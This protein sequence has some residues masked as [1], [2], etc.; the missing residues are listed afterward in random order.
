MNTLFSKESGNLNEGLYIGG[1]EKKTVYDAEHTQKTE[2]SRA[3][4]NNANKDGKNSKSIMTYSKEDVHV[5]PGVKTAVMT[6]QSIDATVM[7]LLLDKVEAFNVFDAIIIDSDS[8]IE[9]AEAINAAFEK[10]M[11]DFSIAEEI[12][13]T[14]DRAYSE[15]NKFIADPKNKAQHLNEAFVNFTVGR[16][17][18]EGRIDI[19]FGNKFSHIDNNKKAVVGAITSYDQYH[20]N[21]GE[22]LVT[23]TKRMTQK[24]ANDNFLN[25]IED[26]REIPNLKETK[27]EVTRLNQLREAYTGL[28]E[29]PSTTLVDYVVGRM[30]EGVGVFEA[31]EEVKNDFSKEEINDLIDIFTDE[32][33]FGS[34]ADR[35]DPTSFSEAAVEINQGNLVDTFDAME[36]MNYTQESKSHQNHLRNVMANIVG[37]VMDTDSFKLHQ[38]KVV[39]EETIGMT[40]QT[41]VYI[42]HE[43]QGN[44]LPQSG[45]L[46]EGIKMSSQEVFAHET[47]HNITAQALTM[48][49]GTVR[50]ITK[51]WRLAKQKVTVEDFM[52]DPGLSKADPTYQAKRASAKARY[53]HIFT[54]RTDNSLSQSVREESLGVDY[55]RN[56]SKHL[57]E[58]VAFGLTNERF[59]QILASDKVNENPIRK[60]WLGEGNI[61]DKLAS[62]FSALLDYLNMRF[63]NIGNTRADVHLQNLVKELVG[64]NQMQKSGL[65]VQVSK[66]LNT[67]QRAIQELV[68]LSG[69]ALTDLAKKP[70]V[71]NSK[72]RVVKIAGRGTRIISINA[73]SAL[74]DA[75]QKVTD[76]VNGGTYGFA[77]QV[78]TEMTRNASSLGVLDMLGRKSNHLVDQQRKHVKTT[79]GNYVKNAFKEPLNEKENTAVTKA[80]LKTDLSVL[81]DSY[82]VQEISEILDTNS[83][84]LASE[85]RVLN[86]QLKAFP[87]LEHFYR[88]SARNLGHFMAKGTAIEEHTLLNAHNI[89]LLAG[90]GFESQISANLNP[91]EEQQR[92]DLIDKLATLY[93]IRETAT[94]HRNTLKSVIDREM[95]LNSSENGFMALVS[96][97]Q[98]FK[99]EAREKLFNG[100]ETLMIKGYTK[101]TYNPNTA[102]TM[103]PSLSENEL[104]R[105][106]YIKQ[107][108]PIKRDSADPVKGDMYMYVSRNGAALSQMQAGIISFTSKRR[109]GTD[110][111]EI[112]D[113]LGNPDAG[114]NGV[115]ND[116]QINQTKKVAINEM[117]QNRYPKSDPSKNLMIP[118]INPNGT[119][120][121]YRYT[122]KEE[123]K[124][125]VLEKD[126]NFSEV[127]GSMFGSII[128]KV[129]TKKI[130]DET[131][132][133]LH[134][135]YLA[136][137]PTKGNAFVEISPN[138]PDPHLRE[139][140]D[141]LPKEA[142]E[143]VRRV[144]GAYNMFVDKREVE[145]IFGQRKASVSELFQMEEDERNIMQDLVV[146][147]LN[148]IFFNKNVASRARYTENLIKEITKEAK[149]FIVVKSGV[150]TA[151]NIMSNWMLLKMQGVPI[152]D[153]FNY[154][155]EATTG[156]LRYQKDQ[157]ELDKTK[158]ELSTELKGMNN[159]LKVRNL[160]SKIAEL[161]NDLSLNPV[162]ELIQAGVMQSIVE[163][164][165]EDVNEYTYK[166]DLVKLV[167]SK[168]EWVNP[169][170][171]ETVRQAYIA[172]DTKLYKVLNNA[173]RMSDFV[174]RYALHQHYITR[175]D[176]PM[177]KAE[178]ISKIVEVFINYDLP[179]NRMIQYAN[180]IGL[181]WFTKYVLRVQKV[182]YDT[183]RENP[184]DTI[185]ALL[186]QNI[187]GDVPDIFDSLLGVNKGLLSVV[188][189][190]FTGL[191]S[192][193][194][195]S[196]TVSTAQSIF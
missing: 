99:K 49:T 136:N 19:H 34:S 153:I 57:H 18:P 85:L 160:R 112:Q 149:D 159:P 64:L 24:D 129:E 119:I 45:I 76:N 147:M 51:L 164:I 97:H 22:K 95:A 162:N 165:E 174:A 31:T 146:K 185:M 157:Q 25:T 194:E 133:E 167:E 173:V 105:M 78:F 127:I 60:A 192:G 15:F 125:T 52:E 88:R 8:T 46:S 121:G 155:M 182:I 138:S 179:T 42:Q 131:I 53:D 4:R 26:L 65:I 10:V 104:S 180:D 172:H 102:I 84:K 124:D 195:Q 37:K 186:L 176:K 29:N 108:T 23:Q 158:L 137:S 151:G 141:M 142:K 188:G 86:N 168:T 54:P 91:A 135:R 6:I 2:F 21:G 13:R 81:V 62:I 50:D 94:E 187:F 36:A 89:A 134:K 118:A 150:V 120:G 126:N 61:Q 109:K 67:P 92:I 58:F 72:N 70:A 181:L 66:V 55:Q 30:S 73:P 44:N 12:K 68:A 83:G 156:M 196:L 113:Q 152:K 43:I 38:K 16:T 107:N 163:D 63:S 40:T 117:F 100:Y 82:T 47:V 170:V 189:D 144:W 41:D 177:S 122:M 33:F 9:K 1:T 77:Q 132:T 123:T 101:E 161:E 143:E 169:K 90:T 190:P 166:N 79:V 75:V 39:G 184:S 148:L 14:F 183:F 128:D 69:K 111:I 110:S 32:T 80:F 56:L 87:T 5:D 178:S 139:I 130:N 116:A 175:E 114:R 93:A 28:V 27:L 193:V 35:I 7:A 74:T 17:K 3:I 140:F 11:N 191:A 171:K 103:A 48:S 96:T 154:Q 98:D 115:L 106:G 71:A 59:M 145:I 20:T